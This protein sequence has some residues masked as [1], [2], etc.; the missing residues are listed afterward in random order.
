L[1]SL[2]GEG[3]RDSLEHQA[4]LQAYNKTKVSSTDTKM[5]PAKPTALEKKKNIP[6]NATRFELFRELPTS[7]T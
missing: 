4:A 3:V 7:S 5:D 1:G 6:N 2:R